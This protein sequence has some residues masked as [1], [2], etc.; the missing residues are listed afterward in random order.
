MNITMKI[1]VMTIIIMIIVMNITMKVI[2]MTMV[3]RMITIMIILMLRCMPPVRAPRNEAGPRMS[4][5][6][7][8]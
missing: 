6:K 7:V 2:I 1:I 3:I 4:L 5:G 8:C